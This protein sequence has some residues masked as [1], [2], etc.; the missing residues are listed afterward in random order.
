MLDGTIVI[1]GAAG[2]IGGAIAKAFARQGATLVLV[3]RDQDGL[4]EIAAACEA[5]GAAKSLT[6][7][8]DVFQETDID[9][10]FI[11][12]ADVLG[13]VDVLVNCSGVISE[14]ALEDMSLAEWQHIVTGNLDSVFLACR[15]VLPVMK[16]Q[17]AGRII[18]IAS[19][20]GQRGAPRFAHYAAAK[21]GV[22]ALTK[23]LAREVAQAGILV[24]A[25]APGPVLTKFN[26]TL[27][28]ETLADTASK[29]PLGRAA[30]PEEIAGAVLL[31]ASDP[32]GNVFVGQTLCPNSGD[33]ML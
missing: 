32:G 23:S 3:D 29:L 20:I 33:V 17:G 31:L 24:N 27:D 2:G 30:Q 4:K 18:N 26:A 16:K 15:A 9:Q 21:A 25:V 14:C 22:I 12:V 8:C 11:D 10:L 7:S 13:R 1:T 5:A 28:P 6:F 19:Q